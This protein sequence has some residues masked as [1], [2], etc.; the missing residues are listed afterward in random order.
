MRIL[1]LGGTQFIGRYLVQA[2]LAKGH[3]LTLFHRGKT[4]QGLFQGVTEI[5]GDRNDGFDPLGEGS[6]DCVIDTCAYVPSQTRRA[7]EE[8]SG[9]AEHF[10]F[11]STRSVYDKSPGRVL[12][13]ETELL[14]PIHEDVPIVGEAYGRM[15]VGCEMLLDEN[16]NG[17]LTHIRPGVVIGPNDPTQRFVYWPLRFSLGGRVIVPDAFSERV[18]GVDVRDLANF[19]VISVEQKL[20]GAY[21]VDNFDMTV[22]DVI[23][24]SSKVA[25]GGTE[26]VVVPVEK[27]KE[28]AEPWQDLPIW[29]DHAFAD[30]DPSKAMKAGLT[31][32]PLAETVAD[33]L[34][35]AESE[36]LELPLKAGWDLAREAEALRQLG[37]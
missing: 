31:F 11:I 32:R 34:A 2:L 15:K 7:I 37:M 28:F 33:T 36:G 13:E 12:T 19:I 20:T 21:N 27:L 25:P 9:K 4:N 26:T 35:W 30:A 1:I 14:E 23:M 22:G 8:L 18:T 5:L 17:P 10:V 16:W 29:S 24:E 6:W 3:D